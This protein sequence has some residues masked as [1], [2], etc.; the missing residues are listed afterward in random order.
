MLKMMKMNRFNQFN[1][2]D[3]RNYQWRCST[4]GGFGQVVGCQPGICSTVVHKAEGLF[5]PRLFLELL[6]AALPS[7]ELWV[8]D[9]SLVENTPVCPGGL[10]LGA[11]LNRER[12][13]GGVGL[14]PPGAGHWLVDELHRLTLSSSKP[15]G[16]QEPAAS[17]VRE[18]TRDS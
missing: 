7:V 4:H 12:A 3:D 9:R 6:V 17:N 16:Y 8:G 5:R 14:S 2:F 10:P 1:Q 13:I 15:P 18:C 11:R